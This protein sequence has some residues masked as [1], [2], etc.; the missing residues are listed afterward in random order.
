MQVGSK[1]W[2]ENF[3]EAVNTDQEL[4]VIGK[5]CVTDLL[6]QIGAKEYIVRIKQGKLTNFFEKEALDGWSF[7]IRGSLEAWEKFTQPIPPPMFHE[8]FAAVFQGNL[9]LEGNLKELYANLRYMI[10]FL[11]VTREVKNKLVKGV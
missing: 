2:M 7:A 10:R 9:Q 6:L 8:L 5:Y 4:N 11:D 1:E 3:Q